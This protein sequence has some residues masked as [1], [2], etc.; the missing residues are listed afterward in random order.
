[1]TGPV[2]WEVSGAVLPNVELSSDGSLYW[3]GTKVPVDLDALAEQG[4]VVRPLFPCPVCESATLHAPDDRVAVP[5]DVLL[6]V[7]SRLRR[8]LN[9]TRPGGT[10]D[11]A[12][13]DLLA[14]V[15]EALDG[16]GDPDKT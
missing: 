14:E 4:T 7:E 8:S 10:P 5:R 1:V 9:S 11:R 2:G 16:Q 12:D 15:A 6:R 3:A 13:T